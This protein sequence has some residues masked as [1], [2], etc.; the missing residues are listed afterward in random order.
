MMLPAVC[1]PN[2]TGNIPSATPAAEPEEEPPGVCPGLAGL[3]VGPGFRVANSVVTVLPITTPPAPR[4]QATGAESAVGRHLAQIGE[5]YALGMS[6][7]S[8]TSFTPTGMPCSLP[9]RETADRAAAA[10]R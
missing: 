8:R 9:G 1:V 10:S 6:P 7:V 2:A 5:P 3:A 4:V